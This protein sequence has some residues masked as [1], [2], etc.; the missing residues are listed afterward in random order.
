[1]SQLLRQHY[2]SQVKNMTAKSIGI[3]IPT[4]QAANHLP[5]CL[6]PLLASSLKPKILIIDSS[7]SDNTIEI[8]KKYGVEAFTIP[9][10]TFNHGLT[11]EKGRKILATDIVVMITQ[12]AYATSPDML[13]HLVKPLLNKS[14]SISYAQQIPHQNA[15]FFEAFPRSF[16]YP[17]ESHIRGV[18]A[19]P[20]YGAYT[21]FCSN[22]CAAYLNETLD[23]VGGFPE[24]LFGEDTLVVAKLLK[25]GHRI[26]YV[27]EAKVHHSHDYTLK[28]EFKRHFDMGLTRQKFK[29]LL[30]SPYSVLSRGKKFVLSMLKSLSQESPQ[31]IP[32]AIIQ[33]GIKFTG[34]QLGKAC[35]SAPL[36]VKKA[37]SSQKQYWVNPTDRNH[38][39]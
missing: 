9:Q 38:H 22:S 35:L 37:F 7:S 1:M 13:Y 6:R 21:F 24:T 29:V 27:A 26:A 36:W 15:G 34:F 30:D 18:E 2:I 25:R 17:S 28:Q 3:F 10:K 11:R 19:F 5:Q 32:Y 4:Y 16:N 12:D 14:A 8:A 31:L 39:E 20:T 23:E 33:Q